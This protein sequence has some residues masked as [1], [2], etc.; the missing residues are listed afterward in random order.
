MN[1]AAG[2]SGRAQTTEGGP[3]RFALPRFCLQH[4]GEQD[5]FFLSYVIHGRLDTQRSNA[6]LFPT[7]FGS[8]HAANSWI[9]GPG[10]ALDTN[11]Y[12]IVV[13][14]AFANGQSSSP[15]NMPGASRGPGFPA[16]S[17]LDNVRAQACLADALG[18][19]R[20]Q[21]VIGRSMGA[22]QAFQWACYYPDRVA[23]LFALCGSARTTGHNYA[24]LEGVKATLTLDPAFKGG[25]YTTP[26]VDGLTAVGVLYAGWAM[27][28]AFYRR[29]LYRGEGSN[30]ASEYI[31]ARWSR[32]F[33]DKDAND[34]LNLIHT[35]QQ[36]DIA[37]NDVFMGDLQ[38]ALAAI[39]APAIVMPSRTDL[40]FPPED[41]ATAVEGMANAS[42]QV[43]ESDWGHRAGGPRS[44]PADIAALESAISALLHQNPQ[45]S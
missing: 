23:R 32:N 19:E 8:N 13:V 5:G 2:A 22:Q 10:R 6:I 11:R 41:S 3:Y 4:G 44:D 12:C 14:N 39:R 24:F 27:S 34:L 21:L 33:L 29:Q 30:S 1:T 17:L 18:I 25:R 37:A 16:I 38:K 43:L 28:Q 9:I 36:A 31:Q 20:W 45:I 42:L 15:S 40:Y 35:W 7:W 26:P